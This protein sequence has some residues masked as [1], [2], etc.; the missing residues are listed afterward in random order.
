MDPGELTSDA[1]LLVVDA[2]DCFVDTL[3]D[4]K[5]F[6]ARCAFS[7]D[8]ART[9]GIQTVFTEQVPNKLGPT[10]A[11]LIQRAQSPAVFP[12]T[13]F[14]ALNAP[15]LKEFLRK[16]E[17]YH[18]LVCGLE[19]PICIY[20][21][22]LQA[23][24]EDFDLTFLSDALGCRR[25]EDAPFALQALQQL[26]CPILP[27]ETV[28]YGI[29]SEATHPQ[30]RA[31]SQLVKLYSETDFSI[32]KHLAEVPKFPKK[33][34]TSRRPAPKKKATKTPKKP[35]VQRKKSNESPKRP[36]KP[37]ATATEPASGNAKAT[38]KTP[39][40]KATKKAARKQVARKRTGTAQS[41]RSK[42]KRPPK[43]DD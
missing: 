18:L 3:H 16:K 42:A 8:A 35:T 25:S 1:A 43:A 17:I 5:T 15:G 12:K 36:R 21:T 14:S 28:F 2:Q 29:L 11:D 38:A 6:L 32:E 9:L 27:S 7:I 30:F 37:E 19:T 26:G 10:R 33:Q 13:S 39:T 41:S 4:K 40:R 24:S 23:A 34:K 22:G 31:F 20:Q